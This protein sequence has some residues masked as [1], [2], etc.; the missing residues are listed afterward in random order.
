MCGKKGGWGLALIVVITGV[1]G[2]AALRAQPLPELTAG[3]SRLQL[4]YVLL[5]LL[6]MLCFVACEALCSRLILGGLGHHLSYLNCLGCSFAGFYVSSIT[7][8]STGGQPAQIYFMRRGGVPVAHG[9]LDMLLIAVCYQVAA[10]LYA[11]AAFALLPG[12]RTALGSGIG[13]LFLYGGAAMLLLTAAMLSMMFLPDAAGRLARGL[14]GVGV[15][16]RLVR[17]PAQAG[18]RLNAQLRAYRQGADCIRKNLTLVPLLMAVT[19]V[20]L[21]ALYAVPYVV[22]LGFGLRGASFF[23]LAGTQA[24]I[25]VAVG[26]L[27]LPGGVGAA[28]GSAASAFS[29]FFGPSLVMPAVLAARGVSFYGFLVLSGC[30][31]MALYLKR[32]GERRQPTPGQ[33]RRRPISPGNAG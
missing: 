3:L 31:T 1:M 21:T 4:R 25:A 13:L 29:A 7:P 8:S 17:R 28:E 30:V 27:P 19:L 22:Y 32:P 9:S 18:A 6:L 10:L 14:L 5:G 20:Q 24:V 15:R 23:E 33:K 11:G 16:L 12:V 26:L 2:I